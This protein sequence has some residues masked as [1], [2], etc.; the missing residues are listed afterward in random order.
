MNRR[1]AWLAGAMPFALALALACA[2]TSAQGASAADAADTDTDAAMLMRDAQLSEWLGE[3]LPPATSVCIQARLVGAWP[4]P[5]AGTLSER[6][7]DRLRLISESC[8]TASTG[9]GE[10]GHSRGLV[11][12]ARIDFQARVE[13]LSGL[14]AAVR[15]CTAASSDGTAQ[16][17]CLERVAARP[18]TTDQARSLVAASAPSSPPPARSK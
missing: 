7:E 14:H 8:A 5:R 13:R 3:P 17:R 4:R 1:L 9:G 11:V 2:R 12:S 15:E 18:I 16:A 6:E 10:V